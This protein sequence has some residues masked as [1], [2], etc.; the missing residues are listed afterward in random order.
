LLCWAQ[1]RG[2]NKREVAYWLL[3]KPLG[4]GLLPPYGPQRNLIECLGQLRRQNSRPLLRTLRQMRQ[5]VRGFCHPL[6]EFGPERASGLAR[7]FLLLDAQP[8]A[9]AV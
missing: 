2:Y 9:R 3:D 4:P 8:S 5:A 1:A 7:N 6:D